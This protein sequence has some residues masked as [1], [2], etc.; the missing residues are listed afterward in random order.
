[1]HRRRELA[2][3]VAGAALL[4]LAL[5]LHGAVPFVAVPALGQALWS[6][7]FSQSFAS[8]SLLSVYATH[9]GAPQPAP[10]SF[11]LAG[12]WPAGVFIAAG[13]HPADAYAAMAALWLGVA[14]VSAYALGRLLRVAPALCLLGA[15]LWLGMPVIWAHADYSML[16][17]GI[18]L[19]PF[20][21]LCSLLVVSR[22]PRAAYAVLLVLACLVA[23]FMDG[24]SFV[25]FAA[26]SGILAAWL[27]ARDP[28][29][30]RTLLLWALPVHA[31][32]LVAA[33][34][35]Y[36]L[37]EGGLDYGAAPLDVF[38]AWGLDL[39][40][41]A[42]PT[43]GVHWLPDLLGLSAGRSEERFFG[44]ASAWRTTFAAPLL[45]VAAWGWWRARRT[46]LLA[47]GCLL[48]MLAA[49]Y[50]ALG[51]SLKINAVKPAGA[52]LGQLMPER[53]ALAPTGSAWL[54]SEVPGLRSMR[55]AYRW[56]ALAVFAG[57]LLLM[58]W[59]STA[60]RAEAFL[61]AA[62]ALG[63]GLLSLPHLADK[64][65]D[66]MAKRAMFLRIDAQLVADMRG[67]LARGERVAF[68]PYRND[69]LA[70]YL[71]ARLELVAYNIG[72]DKNLEAAQRHWPETLRQ[73]PMAA[74]EPGFP[75][76]V[77]LLLVRR[78]ADAVVLPY[79]DLAIA[80]HHRWPR[81]AQ[82]RESLA[83]VVSALRASGLATVIERELYA[84]VRLEQGVPSLTERLVLRHFC[85]PPVCLRQSGFAAQA[86]SRVGYVHLGPRAPLAAG[87][88]RFALHG[89]AAAAGHSWVE[90]VSRHTAR[91]HAKYPLS[92]GEG[93][94]AE[95]A[96]SLEARAEDLEIRVF[97]GEGDVLRLDGY[98]LAPAARQPA[99]AP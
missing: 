8:D 34:C 30:R 10:I 15:A 46:A 97:V 91:R 64:W 82:F 60:A 78:E 96:V 95:G 24:Y 36:V 23:A 44:D 83:P 68:L 49:L 93:V 80:G 79:I 66:D 86:T 76:Q 22:E 17:L 25:M 65:R 72:G 43:E 33:G 27:F 18:A 88:F 69:M 75:G 38:R 56:L 98:E 12:A 55:A 39:A 32:G 92:A 58:L 67:L 71:A 85:A 63:V 29:R 53:Y 40:Y 21:F 99:R 6:T 28:A 62:L 1:M 87:R 90:V 14:F 19:L 50:L 31:A 57:W 13:L 16:S 42:L 70:N 2:R 11:G 89:A 5:V 74:L 73:I 37:Y 45:G 35:L 48:V 81:P 52:Q 7:G 9:F 3:G 41:L 51:P 84:V 94:L 26:G 20:Y 59:L 77:L 4:G 61:A 47:T 54:S